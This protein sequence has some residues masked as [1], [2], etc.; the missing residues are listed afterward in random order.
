[1]A[2][3]SA[4]AYRKTS[5]AP[6]GARESSEIR[7]RP[8]RRPIVTD[9]EAPDHTAEPGT[10]RRHHEMCGDRRSERGLTI[11]ELLVVFG[12]IAVL[13]GILIFAVTNAWES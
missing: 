2:R 1:V 11:I 10:S 7:A 6:S 13:T 8:E 3:P 12:L 4:R 9:S 5:A